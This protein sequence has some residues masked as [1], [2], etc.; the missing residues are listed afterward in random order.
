M[1][2]VCPSYDSQGVV[3]HGRS[4]ILPV[5]LGARAAPT[6]LT[7]QKNVVVLVAF[8]GVSKGFVTDGRK[9]WCDTHEE[10]SGRSTSGHRQAEIVRFS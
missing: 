10:L 7:K 6:R 1:Q 4:M 5:R 3:R 2:G 9:R 8:K